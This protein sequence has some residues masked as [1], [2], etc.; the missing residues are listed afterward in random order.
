V[1][2]FNETSGTSQWN[3]PGDGDA[4]RAIGT[5]REGE[6][7]RYGEPTPPNSYAPPPPTATLSTVST[8][9]MIQSRSLLESSYLLLTSGVTMKKKLH[10]ET[11]YQDRIIRVTEDL[12]EFTWAKINA[13]KGVWKGVDFDTIM[14]VV[15]KLPERKSKRMGNDGECFS[16]KHK[17]GTIDCY[18]DEQ[19]TADSFHENSDNTMKCSAYVK[20]FNTIIEAYGQFSGTASDFVNSFAGDGEHVE[21]VISEHEEVAKQAAAAAAAAATSG[22]TIA[23][24]ALGGSSG[25]VGSRSEDDRKRQSISK[26]AEANFTQHTQW[27]KYHHVA[28]TPREL[29]TWSSAATSSP[30]TQLDGNL[31]K[32]GVDLFKAVV[33][34]MGEDGKGSVYSNPKI[35]RNIVVSLAGEHPSLI[36]EVYCILVKQTSGNPNYESER[37]GWQ[38][39]AACSAQYLPEADLSECVVNHANRSRFRSDAIGGLA[40]FVY[41]RVMLGEKTGNSLTVSSIDLGEDDIKDIENC[42]ICES[43]YGA[44]L[45]GVLR[46]ELFTKNPRAAMPPPG[47]LLDSYSNGVPVVLRLLTHAVIQLGGEQCEGVFRL[48]AQKDDVDYIR[49]EIRNG[50]YRALD[51]GSSN[52]AYTGIRVSDPLV[53]ADLLK[54]FLRQMKT[55]LIPSSLYSKCVDI[56]RQGSA[57]DAKQMI[58]KFDNASRA[59]LEHLFKFVVALSVH[60]DV[61]KMTL[62]NLCL[63]FSPN[64]LKNPSDD[65]MTFASNSQSEQRFVEHCCENY[66]EK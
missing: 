50:D 58:D 17:N 60:S 64:L 34:C 19:S 37:R 9:S 54:S 63:V 59:C 28:M 20:A 15:V 25:S 35:S 65:A 27:K 24:R 7:T 10:P 49:D 48:A 38:L 44:T 13:K 30:L 62:S 1:Y 23:E 40:F 26:F 36:A 61:T 43:V 56:G 33:G 29:V 11:K 66:L 6:A 8:L 2:Y 41:Q 42:Y 12:K 47:V 31:H 52:P 51:V 21:E 53:A 18:L 16:V 32:A 57:R 4:D 5:I 14:E 39:L 45:E 46:K 22:E 3:K 55:P